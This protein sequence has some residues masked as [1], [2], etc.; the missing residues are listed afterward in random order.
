MRPIRKH[1]ENR[2]HFPL[3]IPLDKLG[4]GVSPTD[5]SRI[6]GAPQLVWNW[7]PDGN[8]FTAKG[9][10]ITEN[11]FPERESMFKDSPVPSTR[12]SD[13]PLS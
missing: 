2:D 11:L 5:T 3:L 1:G 4:T 6:D 9:R 12:Y 8:V 10:T 7:E 13:F